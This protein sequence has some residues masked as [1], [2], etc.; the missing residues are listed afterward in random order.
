MARFTDSAFRQLCK[1]QG[2]DVMT[3]E[4][5][6]AES[7][8]RTEKA[9][10]NVD[11][12][13]EQRP[14]GVQIFGS[15]PDRMAAAARAIAD[16]V[17]PDFIDINCGCPA[18]RVTDI[19]AGSSLLKD[20]PMLQKI[21]RACVEAVPEIPITVK[22]RAGWDHEQIVALE[23][24]QRVQDAGAAL[25]AI[26][27]RTKEQGY[28]GEADWNLINEV[29]AALA[30]PVVGNGGVQ[31][32]ADV[33]ALSKAS[34][35]SGIMIGRAALGYP[36]LFAEIKHFLATGEIPPPPSAELRWETIF[37]FVEL[38]YAGPYSD[39][40]RGDVGWLRAKVKA[41]TKDMPLGRKLRPII[42]GMQHLD[43]LPEIAQNHLKE[44]A[45][46]LPAEQA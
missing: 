5:V 46:R 13:E 34:P 28:R 42:D 1:E 19:N 2:A 16:R 25:L 7:L 30:I 39:K 22:I 32:C 35:V 43:E 20:P 17:K 40:D 3:T 18:S 45:E 15:L 33:A 12:T 41:L 21:T 10:R 6:M 23:V 4:F 26:H 27:G 44:C 29:A 31:T 36:W 24:G 8:L 38:L 14:M 37:R 11:F 9:W